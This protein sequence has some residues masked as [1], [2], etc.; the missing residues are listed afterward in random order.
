M[1][2]SQQLVWILP[3]NFA[4]SELQELLSSSFTVLPRS[5]KKNSRHWYDTFDWRLFRKKRLLTREGENWI[6]RDFQ[7]VQLTT[8]KSSGKTVRFA[9]QFPDSSLRKILKNTLDV[10]A[11]LQLGV[12][13]LQLS[14]C[15]ILDKDEAIIAFLDV[16]QSNNTT[17]GG[18]RLS[19][20]LRKVRGYGKVLK[21][22]SD[23]L[24]TAGAVQ[25][26][27]GGD[28]L[29]LVLQGSGC[30]PLDYSSRYAVPLL[31]ETRSIDALRQIYTFLLTSMRQNK[32]GILDDIDSEFLHDFRVAV[33]RTRS[34][35]TLIK[36]VLPP[37]VSDH[38]KEAFRYIGQI[39]GP[40]RDLDVY[41]LS[42]EEYKARLP[43]RLQEG[44][45]YFFED[46]KTKRKQE[47]QKL[48]RS[49]RSPRYEKILSDWHHLLNEVSVLPAGKNGEV[50]ISILGDKIIH[51]RFRRVLDDGRKI[52]R[53]TPDSSLHRLRIQCKKLRYC[54]EFFA[55]LYEKRNMKMLTKQLKMLQNNL[56]D[57]NDLSVQQEMLTD[58]LSKITPGTRKSLE[59][60]ASI[61]GLMTDLVRRHHQ[62]RSHFGE[63]FSHFSRPENLRLYHKLFG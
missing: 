16:E 2:P 56:G 18:E 26:T 9:R 32:Q 12:E 8:L 42:E 21:Q 45:G 62:V 3:E 57:L 60:A 14:S 6:L 53:D 20:H 36:D 23:V 19:V 30:E 17:Q 11:L 43:E 13:E 5:A 61:G 46:L 31:P 33:R 28:A 24:K 35:L 55:P 50:P 27:S 51:K 38:F 44:M 58:Y 29:A 34:A 7:G 1:R 25:I 39:T 37:E 54:L 10:R 59:M 15:N 52:R 49:L 4:L 40:T 47:Q 63:T 41:L 22:I 48:V